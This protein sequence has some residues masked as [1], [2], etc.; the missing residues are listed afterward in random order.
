M[1]T[2]VA[3]RN[4]ATVTPLLNTIGDAPS[5]ERSD[6]R[7]A[8]PGFGIQ[9]NALSSG[10]QFDRGLAVRSSLRLKPSSQ[11][12]HIDS[13]FSRNYSLLGRIKFP[14]PRFREFA[15]KPQR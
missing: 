10:A 12:C 15:A 11:I 6:G 8:R 2:P 3:E 4:R 14:A 9:V 13:L 5:Q 1:A 7:V